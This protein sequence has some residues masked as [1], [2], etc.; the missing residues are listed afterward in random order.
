MSTKPAVL[1]SELAH[2]ASIPQHQYKALILG[3]VTSVSEAAL[4][5]G[6]GKSTIHAA[7][8]NGKLE[9]RL[10]LTGGAIHITM[11]SL[12]Q[13]WGAPKIDLET[14]Y[15]G[16]GKGKANGNGSTTTPLSTAGHERRNQR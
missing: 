15:V 2:L 6:K 3:D 4:L 7:I 1:F 11:R 5:F 8:K 16:K 9:S 13:L 12:I 14:F 10:S